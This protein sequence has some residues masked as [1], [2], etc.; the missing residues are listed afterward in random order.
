MKARQLIHAASYGPD[1]LKVLAQAFDEAWLSVA[2][3]FA[4]DPQTVEAARFKLANAVLSVADEDSR[5]AEA[6]KRDALEAMAVS[7]RSKA[8]A[9]TPSYPVAAAKA[10]D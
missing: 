5:D 10:L 6:V 1:V 7:Y 2:G 3:N 9:S 8:A 4:D